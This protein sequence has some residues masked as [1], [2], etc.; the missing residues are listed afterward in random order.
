MASLTLKNALGAPIF[1]EEIGVIIPGPIPGPA[2]DTF[3]N[4]VLIRSL[5]AAPSIRALV[6]A[7]TVVVN[8]GISDL[9]PADGLTYL[10]NLWST[11]GTD[12]KPTVGGPPGTWTLVASGFTAL[13]ADVDTVLATVPVA[14]GEILVPLVTQRAPAVAVRGYQGN[15]QTGAAPGELKWMLRRDV[16]SPNV[17]F[18]AVSDPAVTIDW[19]LYKIAP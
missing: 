9:A 2:Q 18:R 11:A 6:L 10:A 15:T 3:T 16:A 13:V 8:D 17:E 4:E 12:T 14:V 7:G 1:V 5:A 19:R